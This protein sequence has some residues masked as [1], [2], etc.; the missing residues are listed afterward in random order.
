MK[1][2]R[3]STPPPPRDPRPKATRLAAWLGL[4]IPLVL[5]VALACHALT[6]LDIWLHDRAGRDILAAGQLP[7][8]N[9]FSFTAPE[10]AWIDHEWLF[11]VVVALLGR[12]DPAERAVR[13]TGLAIALA[14]ALTTLLWRDGCAVGRRGAGSVWRR[15]ATMAWP[16]VGTLLLLWTRLEPR[17]ELVSLVALAALARLID[18]ALADLTHA[19]GDRGNTRWLVLVSPRTPA[20]RAFWLTVFWA[21][22]HGFWLLA[23]ALWLLAAGLAPL[24]ARLGPARRETRGRPRAFD[25]PLGAL[26]PAV[27]TL[28]AGG[29]T[30]NHVHGL[31]YPLRA[32]AHAGG[33]GV[34]LRQFIAEM[35]PLLSA[36]NHLGLTVLAF[37]LAVAW[38]AVWLI[39]TAGRVPIWRATLMASGLLAAVYSQRN[40]GLCAV[41]LCLGHGGY[42]GRRAW[43][44]SRRR[45]ALSLA[46]RLSTVAPWVALSSAALALALW[47]PPIANDT[48]FLREGTTWRWGTGLAPTQYPFAA[49]RRLR[50]TW[51][52]TPPRVANNINAASTLV[53]SAAGLVFVDG[54][55]EA[56]PSEVWREYREFRQGGEASLA[57]L[58]RRDVEAVLLAHAS[59][60]GQNLLETLLQSARWDLAFA[61]ESG[62][63]FL[64]ATEDRPASTAAQAELLRE[65]AQ[66]LRV[67]VAATR[68]AR[69][70]DRCLSLASLL[71]S[72][73][74]FSEAEEL[75]LLG[76]A[77]RA[78]HPLLNHNRGNQL[79]RRQDAV[80]A[81][82]HFRAAL[83]ANPN[84]IDTRLNL[85][86]ALF[87]QGDLRGAEREFQAV[88]RA[89]ARRVEAWANLGEARLRL[90][91]R[92]GATEAFAK[93]LALRPGDPGIRARAAAAGR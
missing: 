9:G 4:G 13:W 50:D 30:P 15:G 2:S 47:L 6:D 88:T 24:D 31:V 53:S 8:A 68:G 34:D 78:D 1:P 12:G 80:G 71:E 93:A 86:V 85:G 55:T 28:L 90:G 39:A 89:A 18:G 38:S 57:I 11:Q 83:A 65:A 40:L 42:D 23:P 74:L 69:A 70:A 77:A 75:L 35:T 49:A 16:L 81:A 26:G 29:L 19:P 43:F 25:T 41:A 76:L 45:F 60:G 22:V 67:S 36:E 66:S 20:G 46:N 54:R 61:D 3:S 92:E 51:T 44:W 73:G 52:N 63:L 59:G 87:G 21:Q 5:T 84:L 64:P 72:A 79:L 82:R 62:V 56:Y 7:R 32:L 17:P 10:H 14:A 58:A 48:F 91:D 33:A 37:K 27:A